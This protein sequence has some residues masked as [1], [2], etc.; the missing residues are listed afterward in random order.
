MG[1]FQQGGH[2]HIQGQGSPTA[3]LNSVHPPIRRDSHKSQAPADTLDH[4]R[5]LKCHVNEPAAS[6][7]N[8]NVSSVQRLKPYRM[9]SSDC[10]KCASSCQW[11]WTI[12][13]TIEIILV[14]LLWAD[15]LRLWF[16]WPGERPKER[17]EADQ[18]SSDSAGHCSTLFLNTKKR[19]EK[20][21]LEA[22]YSLSTLIYYRQF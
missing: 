1:F 5:P 19:I 8:S 10:F 4:L 9:D 14:L 15:G 6:L 13:A 18:R 2:L 22:H 17:R 16:N 21:E 20:G 7:M 11:K 12:V 3:L